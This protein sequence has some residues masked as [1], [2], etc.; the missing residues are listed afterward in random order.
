MTDLPTRFRDHR[1]AARLFTRPGTAIVAVSGGPDSVGL[2]DLLYGVRDEWQLA[3]VVAHADHGIQAHSSAVAATVRALAER[4]GLAFELGEL[5]LGRAATE[6]A[7]RRARYEWLRDVQRRLRAR[8]LVTAHHAD[9]Q[10]ET[11]LLRVLRGSAP[12]GLAG[13]PARGTGGLVRPLLSF[14][15]S[16]LMEYAAARGLPVHDDPANRDRR[17][18]RSWVRVEL[19]PAITARLGARALADLARLARAAAQ[20]RHAWDRALELV[21]ELG[22][23]VEAAGFSVAR[24]VL[25]RYDDNLGVALLRAAARRVGLVLGP[26]RAQRLLALT[27]GPSGRR[28]ELGQGWRGE[29]AFARLLVRRPGR[30]ARPG[31]LVAGADQGRAV[32]GDFAV[33]WRPDR[34]PER[35]SREGWTTW[36]EGPGWEVRAPAAGDVLRPLGGV[37][38]RPVRRLL[39]EAR[40]PRATR[41]AYP[42]LARGQTILWVPGVC[43]SADE[44]P[45]PGTQAVRV[46]VSGTAGS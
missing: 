13:M 19:L 21:P 6:T 24:G 16:E 18:L 31:R 40:V 43:R 33:A 46:D 39:M 36:L 7:A 35:V 25:G 9:D 30:P 27:R 2:L 14:T 38:R 17:H 26:Q 42:I 8:Y 20:E 23:Q 5:R 41:A 12:A 22:V 10:I 37:G 4:Y 28:V 1:T 32:F 29:A 3:L 34:A 44:L 15:K 45:S 11:V